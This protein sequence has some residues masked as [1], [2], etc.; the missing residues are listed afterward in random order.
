[1]PS[2]VQSLLLTYWRFLILYPSD[3]LDFLTKFLV[4]NK[5]GLKIL[6]DK[7][8]LNQTLFHGKY[9]KNISIKG[10]TNLYNLKN[11]IVESLIVV[12]FDHSDST[13]S[14]EVNAPYKILSILIRCLNNEILVEKNKIDDNSELC[15]MKMNEDYE[16]DTDDIEDDLVYLKDIEYKFEL[17]VKFI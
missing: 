10:L 15:D 12:G 13:A 16:N 2:I 8:V 6:M 17:K 4:E 11:N 7:W 5:I 1:M 14:V 9:F 3:I